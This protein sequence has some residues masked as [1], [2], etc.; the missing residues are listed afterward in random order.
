MKVITNRVRVDYFVDYCK[1]N[2]KQ[3]H[4]FFCGGRGG[5]GRI[6]L[7]IEHAR[8]AIRNEGGEEADGGG[9]CYQ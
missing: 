5:K 8:G 9:V 7:R 6:L 3:K 4:L 2:K 1:C